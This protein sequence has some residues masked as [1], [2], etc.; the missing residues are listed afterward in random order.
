MVSAN[1]Q[2]RTNWFA[3]DEL[4]KEM[5]V[6]VRDMKVGEISDPF[7]TTDESNNPVFRIIRL[8]N[9]MQAHSANL[10]DDYQAICNAAVA[11]ERNKIYDKWI[12]DKIKVT[13]LKISDEYKSCEFLKRGWLK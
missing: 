2:D 11:T 3:L 1:P 12:K 5:Y 8:D 10:K 4:N 13:Y 6:K 7:R 9:E